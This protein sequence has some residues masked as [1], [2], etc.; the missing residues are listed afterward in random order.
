[1][2]RNII[3]EVNLE[4]SYI[5]IDGFPLR[6]KWNDDIRMYDGGRGIK[7]FACLDES[8][9]TQIYLMLDSYYTRLDAAGQHAEGMFSLTLQE[10]FWGGHCIKL[11]R[12][13]QRS[14]KYNEDQKWIRAVVP[15]NSNIS[16][17]KKPKI[18]KE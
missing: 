10:D 18:N 6:Y 1:M 17:V 13:T 5:T 15:I 3:V 11:Y 16:L 4:K 7:G 2:K 12:N 9:P 14:R 8:D